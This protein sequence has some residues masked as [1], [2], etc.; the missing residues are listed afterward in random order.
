MT[1]SAGN[2]I[3]ATDYNGFVATTVGANINAT[4]NTTYGQTAIAQVSPGGTVTA[5]QWASLV[6]TLSAMGAHQGTT[7]TSR[8]APV[9]GNTISILANVNT[10]ITNCYTNRAN[11]ATIGTQYTAWTGSANTSGTTGSGSSAWQ[12]TFTDTVTFANASAASAFFGAGGLLKT[13]FSKTSTGTDADADWNDFIGNVV[14]NA[15]VYLSGANSA[16]IAGT[17]YTG[18]TKFGGSGTP[19]T[20]ATT[21]NFTNLTTTPAVIYKQFYTAAA[22]SSD[23]V[24]ITANVNA[25]SSPT[26]VTLET[27]WFNAG[28]ADPGANVQISGGTGTT[29]ITFGTAP[30]TVVT[31][32]PPE[33]T[34]LTNTWGTPTVASTVATSAPGYA[35]TYLVVAGG[36][37][38]GTNTGG[39]GGAGGVLT[40]SIILIPGSTYTAVVGAGGAAIGSSGFPGNPGAN[41]TFSGTNSSFTAV[42]GGGGG[43]GNTGTSGL[44]TGQNGGSGGGGGNP[45]SSGTYSGGTGAAGQGYSG[46]QGIF[47]SPFR[48]SGGG[49]GASA[50]GGAASNSTGGNG[51]A[52]V[53]SS[54][55]GSSVTYGGGGGASGASANGTGGAGG[56]GNAGAAGT[57]GLGGGGGGGT[58]SSGKGGNGIVILSVATSNY[59]GTTTGSPTVT[60]S[61]SNTIISFTTGTGTYVA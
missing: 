26:V 22:Y 3:V 36:G 29:G 52:G 18:T 14:A 12:L 17:T 40:G 13:Q 35:G 24:Q 7:I 38:G 2:I 33:T 46:G 58:G 5:T 60:T 21:T 50:A 56:G 45:T 25:N 43:Q 1:Y 44:G 8:T 23:Y 28:D 59:T 9:T 10:D 16:N 20:L 41:S 54:I 53:A 31:Y 55:T 51:G 57:D 6:N 30:A 42:G 11:A 49:G 32:F 47:F 4:W 48:A 19:T 37:S 15:G 61:G 39:G 27:T 34:N